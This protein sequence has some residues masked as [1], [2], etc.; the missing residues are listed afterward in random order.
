MKYL[1]IFLMF[2]CWPEGGIILVLGNVME[3]SAT[4][5]TDIFDILRDP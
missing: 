5:T 1:D 2:C 3:T 4:V